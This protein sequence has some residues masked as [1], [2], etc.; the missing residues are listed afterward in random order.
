[1]P[2]PEKKDKTR[3]GARRTSEVQ[4]E[5]AIV[6]TVGPM[7]VRLALPRKTGEKKVVYTR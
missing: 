5:I 6:S 3:R 2:P 4:K 1:M 7:R